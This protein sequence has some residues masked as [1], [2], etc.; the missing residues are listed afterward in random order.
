MYSV[1]SVYRGENV[2]TCP[3][4]C[5]SFLIIC[6]G[7]YLSSSKEIKSIVYSVYR[8]YRVYRVYCV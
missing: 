4:M 5:V 7:I 6:V 3:G 1:Y 2:Y 8:V